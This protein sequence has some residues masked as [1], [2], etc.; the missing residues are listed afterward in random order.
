MSVEACTTRL[1]LV[2][3]DPARLDEVALKSLGSRGVLRLAGGAV[4][5]VVGPVA[6]QLASDIR[7]GMAASTIATPVPVMSLARAVD[8]LGGRDNILSVQQVSSRLCVAV[9]DPARVDEGALG[10]AVRA[11]AR[12]ASDRVHLIVGPAA[13]DWH[14]QLTDS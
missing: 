13:A 8:A 2:V 1:R 6:D 3:A 5:V 7:R 9:R 10:A 4:Q 14:A 11:F 12:P